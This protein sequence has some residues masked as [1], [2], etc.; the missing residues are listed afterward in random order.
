MKE[1]GGGLIVLTG[2]GMSVCSG[3][4]VF[5]NKDGSMSKVIGLLIISFFPCIFTSAALLL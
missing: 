3:V 2:A 1:S 4:P 5:R